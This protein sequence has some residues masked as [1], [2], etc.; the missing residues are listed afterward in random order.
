MLNIEL[1]L[2]IGFF[3]LA[4]VGFVY[5]AIAAHL[6]FRFERSASDQHVPFA[7]S[8]FAVHY[9]LVFGSLYA[10]DIFLTGLLLFLMAL[11]LVLVI[12]LGSQARSKAGIRMVL[13][14]GFTL[15][16]L[17]CRIGHDIYQ[18]TKFVKM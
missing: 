15:A 5:A 16:A 10:G 9:V 2:P 13:A 11:T 18:S 12:W 4:T 1:A 3:L 7:I 17:I 6:Y 14:G 8:V